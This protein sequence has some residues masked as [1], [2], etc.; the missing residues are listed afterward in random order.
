MAK[1]ASKLTNGGRWYRKNRERILEERRAKHRARGVRSREELRAEEEERYH[2][3]LKLKSLK[4]QT[5]KSIGDKL[6]IS[7][8]AVSG[9]VWRAK[10]RLEVRA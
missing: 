7:R 9:L 2:A 4:G 6:G 5:F 10:N 1:K 8:N 3:I